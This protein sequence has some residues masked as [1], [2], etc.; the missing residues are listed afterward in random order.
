MQR[1]ECVSKFICIYISS[2][3][4][5]E[6]ASQIKSLLASEK[7]LKMSALTLM[8]EILNSQLKKLK[9]STLLRPHIEKDNDEA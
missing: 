9:Q 6:V 5:L 8:N 1:Y 2:K 3:L 4:F 7:S